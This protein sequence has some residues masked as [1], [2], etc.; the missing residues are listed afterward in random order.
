MG[1]SRSACSSIGAAGSGREST[2]T[3]MPLAPPMVVIGRDASITISS[4]LYS[5]V[6]G[7][8]A[9]DHPRMQRR[10]T[11]RRQD[12]SK[13][14]QNGKEPYWTHAAI[15]DASSDDVAAEWPPLVS[16]S[17]YEAP[18][19]ATSYC[20]RPGSGY[21]R[22]PAWALGSSVASGA[23]GVPFDL[24]SGFDTR[25]GSRGDAPR[26]R[27]ET[28]GVRWRTSR[29]SRPSHRCRIGCRR[30]SV[31]VESPAS[32]E[33]ARGSKAKIL[34]SQ[35]RGSTSTFV[36][37]ARTARARIARRQERFHADC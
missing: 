18:A 36:R 19:R 26:L 16:A 23:T 35:K 11:Q 10:A 25:G 20:K 21:S 4:S 15:Q 2:W 37:G 29:R 28:E 33:R 1:R 6:S 12:A 17:S 34:R 5:D 32:I 14:H 24:E 31:R 22:S 7:S 3:S 27:G 30:R 13:G 9:G 8:Q